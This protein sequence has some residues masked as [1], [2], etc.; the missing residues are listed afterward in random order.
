MMILWIVLSIV[1]MMAIRNC[2]REST[3]LRENPPG[4]TVG[5]D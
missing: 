2:F 4:I 1:A 3:E 5:K